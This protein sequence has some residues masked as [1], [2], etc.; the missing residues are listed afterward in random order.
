MTEA[1][2]VI[3]SAAAGPTG[4]LRPGL[5]VGAW[6]VLRTIG[7]GGMGEVFLAERADASF[8]KK[9]ALKLIQG[10]MTPVA[11]A[12]FEAEKQALARLEHPHIARLIDAG[13]TDA[14]W[15]YLVMEFV[16]G[17]PIDHLLADRGIDEVL[18]IFLQVCDAVAYAHR[19]LVLHR[20]IKPSNILVNRQG[21]AKLLDF[22]I[23]KLLQSNDG[24]EDSHTVERAYTPEY[25]SPEQVF[26]RPIGV[27]SDVYSLGVLLYRLLAGVPPYAFEPGDTAALVQALGDEDVPAPSRAILAIDAP[28]SLSHR[29][30]R[31]RLLSGD[32][33]TI[34]LTALRKQSERRYASADALADDI[35]RFLAHQP[36]RAQPDSLHYRAGKFLRRNA[37]TVAATVAVAVS[38][39][40]GLGVSLWQA[41]LAEQQRA[42][43]E[44]RF[45]D[46]RSL[47]HA[48]IFDLHDA[49]VKLPGSTS[50]RSLL[51]QQALTYLQ[52]LGDQKDASVPLQRELAEAWLRVGDVQGEPDMPNLGD[53]RGA[54]A[55]YARAG[56]HIDAIL[57]QAPGDRDARVLQAQVLLHRADVHYET[58]ALAEADAAYASDAL[59][60]TRLRDQHVRG[61]GAGLAKAR[62]GQGKVMFW[63]NQREDALRL[64][65]LAL[66]TM[67][68]N[69]P[70]DAP[71]AYGLFL[72]ANEIRRG[73]TLDWLGRDVEARTVITRA[74]ERLLALQRSHP[75]DPTIRHSVAMAWMK[76]A[77]NSYDLQDKTPV[78]TDCENARAIL[79]R[80]VAADPA[81]MRAKRL[82]A[83]SEQESG[84]ALVDL[85][86]SDEALAMYHSALVKEQEVAAHEPRD[87]TVR[88]DM[89]NTLYGIGDLHQRRHDKK[90]AAEAFRQ[91]LAVRQ[92]LSAQSPNAAA[93]RRDVAQ[94]LGN[95]AAVDVDAG[96]ACRDW[97]ASDAMWQVLLRQGGT[98][99]SDM[100]DVSEVHRQAS[101][102]R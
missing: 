72:S 48:M 1:T 95:I 10:L 21:D 28:S 86:R 84:D 82:L 15:P 35:R 91:A 58:N 45:E 83:L 74:L 4:E 17:M 41:H 52:R 42:L 53:L 62:V 85:K 59:L 36:I 60:W 23:A 90:A 16:D 63:R 89:G 55:S 29:R 3:G 26:G 93:L 56:E 31:A 92:A 12:R 39:V 65:T 25:A 5:R 75:D 22:G 102:C 101:A 9:V 6:R 8:D 11:Q 81:D 14:G 69:G 18:A 68:A 38:L 13:Q 73:E 37:L 32:L 76:L 44:R 66:E 99:P 43:A 30:R 98:S 61:A 49:L 71:L 20:D 96:T 54:L 40:T 67:E 70:D 79:A 80:E 100:D 24:M 57:K 27:A 2:R 87:E 94:V 47:A 46:V 78:L 88:Q 77:E 7:V 50:A 33:D 34:V 51:V 97:K 19:Q 64:F